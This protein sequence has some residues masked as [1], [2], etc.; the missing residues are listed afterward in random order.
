[1]VR[2]L[3]RFNTRFIFTVWDGVGFDVRAKC[4]RRVR[5]DVSVVCALG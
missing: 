2:F 1:M 3:I 4:M 5:S